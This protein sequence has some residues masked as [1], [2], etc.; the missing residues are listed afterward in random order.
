M[1]RRH[2]IS[3]TLASVAVVISGNGNSRGQINSSYTAG[4]NAPSEIVGRREPLD[5]KLVSAF[6]RAGRNNPSRVKS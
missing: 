5:L 1:I 2:F 3:K 4:H 6:V